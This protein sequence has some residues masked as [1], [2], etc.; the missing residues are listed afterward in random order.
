MAYVV[1]ALKY[2]PQRVEEMVGQSAIA[3]TLASAIRTGRLA[4]AYIFGGPR[5]T[6][7]TSMA[8]IFA[9]ALNCEQ[10]P[11]PE[12]CNQC[13]ICQSID[14]GDDMDVLEIDAAS[15]NKVDDIRELR[16]HVR[17]RPVR[18]RFK[19]YYL[20]EA[21]ML[22]KSA[23]N[24][25]LKTLE[26]PPEHVKFI[27]ST[28]EPEKMPE[29][30]LSR[31]QRFDFRNLSAADI[32]AR[33]TQIAG[34]E[35]IEAAPGVLDLIAR[36]ARGGMRDA[37]SLLDQLHAATEGTLT[38]D[39]AIDLLGMLP[40]EAVTGLFQAFLDHDDAH[41]LRLVTGA[42]S[43]GKDLGELVTQAIEHARVL[44]HLQVLGDDPA[45][46]SLP[47][48]EV[49]GLR[50]QARAFSV[51]QLLQAIEVLAR[52]R[53]ELRNVIDA[54][55]LVEATLLE[56]ARL[57]ELRPL[58]ELASKV[59]AL[60]RRAGGGAPAASPPATSAG[61]AKAGPR[62]P[63]TAESGGPLTSAHLRMVQG[64]WPE[65]ADRV[66]GPAGE[67]LA[68]LSPVGV[69][70]GELL[71]SWNE[72]GEPEGMGDLGEA[73]AAA[74]VFLTTRLGHPLKVRLQA[75]DEGALRG[76]GDEE[77]AER[78]GPTG[79][80]RRPPAN[81]RIVHRAVELFDGTIEEGDA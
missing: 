76:E 22:S 2:R 41:I 26:E 38:R 31:C 80:H 59:E 75:K 64:F 67:V 54:Q 24:A 27:F 56:L 40:T 50:S 20:D 25:L 57:D 72:Q 11:T 74:G 60:G 46:G 45:L 63:A 52:A 77:P 33:L 4:Q 73:L 18:A 44:L 14:R 71:V 3:T 32:V 13:D 10:G 30:I 55:V 42:V 35:S 65:L 58:S 7:K 8:R 48:G 34:G 43:Q 61:P 39:A 28:T 6:G 37:I 81:E 62:P 49:E 69:S 53:F 12:P 19:I 51:D 29:T 47:P 66:D 16:E 23:W 9:K 1:L 36:R 5:G 15:R 78:A 17:Y 79:R 21:H 70:G 68:Q